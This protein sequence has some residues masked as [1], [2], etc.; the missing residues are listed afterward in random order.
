MNSRVVHLWRR[1]ELSKL[2]TVRPIQFMITLADLH[3]RIS[4]LKTTLTAVPATPIERQIDDRPIAQARRARPLLERVEELRRH[5]LRRSED[6]RPIL[7]EIALTIADE[8]RHSERPAIQ[9]PR[10]S[11]DIAAKSIDVAR[12]AGYLA[13]HSANLEIAL[14][15]AIA[16]GL[17][18]NQCDVEATSQSSDSARWQAAHEAHPLVAATLAEKALGFPEKWARAIAEHHERVDGSGFPRRLLGEQL[19]KEGKLLA[20]AE[21][22]IDLR[23]ARPDRAALDTKETLVECLRQGEAGV[24]DEACVAGLLRLGFFEPGATV[25][26]TTGELAI[27]VANQ[28]TQLDPALAAKPIVCLLQEDPNP[29]VREAL[30]RNLALWPDVRIARIITTSANRLIDA[31]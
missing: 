5:I 7:N 31:A 2:P 13:R 15:P 24:L 8:V 3:E 17:V 18:M 11:G 27:V 10:H 1:Q 29:R 12:L 9:S 14:A 4:R 21:A 16:A 30:F 25:E 20:V 6:A 23:C 19:C 28:A 26:L 22:Y